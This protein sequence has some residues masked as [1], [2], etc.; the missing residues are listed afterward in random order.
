[1]GTFFRQFLRRHLATP[2]ASL[3][4]LF[5]LGLAFAFVL[6]LIA[7]IRFQI[8]FD[9][10]IPD[11]DRIVML[12]TTYTA[13]SGEQTELSLAPA[14]A[15]ATA[16]PEAFPQLESVTSVWHQK[17]LFMV[18]GEPVEKQVTISSRNFFSVFDLP[19]LYGNPDTALSTPDAVVLSAAE[20][21]RLFGSTSVLGEE[22]IA[23]SSSGERRNFVVS[24]I[25][26]PIP[27]NTHF[28]I[29]LLQ[30][31]ADDL[32]HEQPEL[33]TAWGNLFGYVYAKLKYG[34][35]LSSAN[36][37]MPQFQRDHV[38]DPAMG[39][40]MPLDF[41]FVALADV[42][43][44]HA[45][46][47]SWKPGGDY[48]LVQVFAAVSFVILLVATT[49][50]AILVAAHATK[51][52]RDIAI[53]RIHGASPLGIAF[54]QIMENLLFVTL[55]GVVAL[56]MLP[57]LQ[58]VTSR[59]GYASLP[60]TE[61][62]LILFLP[63]LVVAIGSLATLLPATLLL[64]FRPATIL[65]SRRMPDSPVGRPLRTALVA[66]QFAVATGLLLATIIMF[67]QTH[68][69]RSMDPGY[70]PDGL[71][72]LDNVGQLRRQQARTTL[73]EMIENIQ[74]VTGVA[75]SSILPAGSNESNMP[76]RRPGGE[77]TQIGW[78]AIDTGFFDVAEIPVIAGRGLTRDRALDDVTTGTLEGAVDS[79][80][81]VA[82]GGNVI[83]S[84][85]ALRL[86][87]FQDPSS[88]L[89]QSLD[90]GIV[91]LSLGF[92][93]MTVVGIVGDVRYRSLRDPVRPMIYFQSRDS[94]RYLLV[95]TQPGEEQ[96]VLGKIKD[97][98]MTLF[99]QQPFSGR[100]LG[101]E[102]EALHAEDAAKASALAFFAI[103]AVALACSGIY[104]VVAFS[105]ER[106]RKEVAIRKIVGAERKDM[107]R[108]LALQI[109]KP[110]VLANIIA[111]PIAWWTMRHWLQG[112][113]S[114]ID[115]NPALF[116]AVALGTALLGLLVVTTHVLNIVRT[117]PVHALR[118]E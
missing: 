10:W 44:H 15:A 57:A 2:Q 41:Q 108:L 60:D 70:T 39:E 20:A 14:L 45:H 100:V 103:L 64:K 11:S 74:G 109:L 111:L 34:R 8:S 72:V 66:L 17:S 80:T 6:L 89:G 92:V 47:G 84:T 48:R 106:R 31:Q 76:V 113:E 24:G 18:G 26:A 95:R 42:H 78:A 61:N 37:M 56:M 67:L 12:E 49:N 104:S 21:L 4:S 116:F 77:Q 115:L 32:L 87:G 68:H 1:M 33:L 99:P 22:L 75:G 27:P 83:V 101:Y 73:H 81:L 25:L 36:E 28:E 55:A 86:L 54:G 105:V 114:R 112:F 16:L 107:L 82:R 13:P 29:D 69:A 50:Y 5:C 91:D 117:P 102:V 96:A 38:H 63:L 35:T 3:L 23:L 88:A 40:S 19:L 65:G 90:G 58:I 71:L 7:E 51:R 52:G 9:A 30:P 79:A 98:W 43:L 97:V 62:T 118:T 94:I 46:Q 59:I 110:V 93:P 85:S 53:R